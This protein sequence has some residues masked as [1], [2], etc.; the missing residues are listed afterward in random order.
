MVRC[1][2]FDFFKL[3]VGG[4]TGLCQ[5][6]PSITFKDLAVQRR[7]MIYPLL[8]ILALVMFKSWRCL[9]RLSFTLIFGDFVAWFPPPPINM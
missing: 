8:G 7:V 4:I 1:V 5:L 3:C 9:A 6:I 2:R